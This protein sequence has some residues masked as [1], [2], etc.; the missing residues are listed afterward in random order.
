MANVFGAQAGGGRR[1]GLGGSWPLPVKE[2]LADGDALHR[3]PC[4]GA[5]SSACQDHVP[6]LRQEPH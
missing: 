5:A 1:G 4:E 2:L 6:T 3:R